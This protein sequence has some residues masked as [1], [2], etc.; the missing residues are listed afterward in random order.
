MQIID[1]PYVIA[2]TAKPQNS[3]L[4]PGGLF[5]NEGGIIC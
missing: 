3:M 5:D 1:I 4:L 2:D